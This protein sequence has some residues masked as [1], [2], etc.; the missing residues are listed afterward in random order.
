[1]QFLTNHLKQIVSRR[2]KAVTKGSLRNMSTSKTDKFPRLEATPSIVKPK[3]EWM[4]AL[5]ADAYYVTTEGGTERP[6][7]GKY[8]DYSN[9]GTYKCI[10]CH[11]E[12]FSNDN[13]FDSGCG[14]PSFD[15]AI[16]DGSIRYV[17]DHS[18]GRTRLEVRCK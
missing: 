1:M 17:P 7:T 12:L 13:K 6:W 15:R 10:R 11:A 18:M 16:D 8:N 2:S 14:W 5:D 9:P 3:E 4:K